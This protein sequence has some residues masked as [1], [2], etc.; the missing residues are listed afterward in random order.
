[1]DP[2]ANWA[3]QNANG[4]WSK[5]E[6]VQN[7]HPE[8]FWKGFAKVALPI[9]GIAALKPSA[10]LITNLGQ[11]MTPKAAALD[12]LGLAKPAAWE[13]TGGAALTNGIYLDEK[14]C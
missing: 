10:Q 6:H 5:V 2:G 3:C 4:Q 13:I 8:C 14:G 1:M 11:G 12:A 7:P 9:G